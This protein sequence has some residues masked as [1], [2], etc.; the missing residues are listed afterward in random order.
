[1]MMIVPVDADI[2]ETENVAKNFGPS[3]IS[4]YQSW[5][6]GTLNSNTMIVMII[7][8]TPSL[9]ASIRFAFRVFHLFLASRFLTYSTPVTLRK[10]LHLVK[11][12]FHEL[13]SL[14]SNY[15]IPRT[16]PSKNFAVTCGD[17]HLNGHNGEK[18]ERSCLG[19][20]FVP[21]Q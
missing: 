16:F 18:C 7:A 2:Y 5:P 3:S 8:S 9:N 14:Y 17:V 19:S 13:Q 4:A 21:V 12:N 20:S 6:S 11:Q 10:I 15:N 1:M